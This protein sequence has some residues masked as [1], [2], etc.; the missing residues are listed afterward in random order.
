ISVNISAM[1]LLQDG[2]C[3]GL[4]ETL[5]AEGFPPGMLCLEVTDNI[6]ANNAASAVLADIR[7]LGVHVAIDDFGVGTSSLSYLR[8]L[9]ADLVKLDRGFLDALD[10]GARGDGFVG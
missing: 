2:F 5:E 8:R 6:V 4:C 10:P 3:S 7:K 9:P 1:Q